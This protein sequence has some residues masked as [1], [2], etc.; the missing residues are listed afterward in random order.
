MNR[1]TPNSKKKKLV[2]EKRRGTPHIPVGGKW[3][4]QP[5]TRSPIMR[6]TLRTLLSYLDDTLE[7]VEARAIGQKVAESEQARELAERITQVTRRRRLTTPPASGP[8][9]L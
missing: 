4:A 9:G 1:R 3:A 6:L 7:P 8:G 2:H 5:F